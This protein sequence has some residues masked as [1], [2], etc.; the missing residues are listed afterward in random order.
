MAGL[1][2]AVQAFE[3]TQWWGTADLAEGL[4]LVLLLAV[5][6]ALHAGPTHTYRLVAG[7]A[8]LG[9]L[10][11]CGF[12]L[13]CATSAVIHQWS[14][15]GP[16]YAGVI[17]VS[18]A[19]AA[20]CVRNFGGGL[21]TAL[22]VASHLGLAPRVACFSTLVLWPYVAVVI[23][24]GGGWMS[25]LVLL[26]LVLTWARPLHGCAGTATMWVVFVGCGAGLWAGLLPCC[27]QWAPGWWWAH[28]LGLL[29]YYCLMA[30]FGAW[31]VGSALLTA[32][33][34]TL[35]LAAFLVL[36]LGVQGPRNSGVRRLRVVAFL[37]S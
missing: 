29:L 36:A 3:S 34:A 9:A 4:S 1:V 14:A 17:V 15:W 26:G 32:G 16:G 18:C 6:G 24:G 25:L 8:V 27:A 37:S 30:P 13:P 12:R 22:G 20:Y 28:A 2:W 19:C 10:L 11:A 31:C 33:G 5:A 7:V 35:C 21:G 23:L